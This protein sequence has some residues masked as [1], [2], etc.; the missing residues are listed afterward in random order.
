MG[1]S[2]LCGKIY[3]AQGDKSGSYNSG[4]GLSQEPCPTCL[5]AQECKS[6]GR[7]DPR[8][9]LPLGAGR[10]CRS[11]CGCS[12]EV[13]SESV[14]WVR[15][16]LGGFP[17]L[18]HPSLPSAVAGLCGVSHKEKANKK[19][20]HTKYDIS[21]LNEKNRTQTPPKEAWPCKISSKIFLWAEMLRSRTKPRFL[22][23]S[24]VRDLELENI[25]DLLIAFLFG[26]NW[27][28]ASLPLICIF[29]IIIHN[30]YLR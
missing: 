3:T 24:H 7:A 10:D 4:K 5:F 29:F 18:L 27:P 19:N 8:M 21:S 17:L 2:P 9:R 16:S 22:L 28:P 26:I 23:S 25:S 11:P 12:L 20:H 30:F 15:A 14:G 13:H 6:K 1:L